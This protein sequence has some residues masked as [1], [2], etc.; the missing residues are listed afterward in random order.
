MDEICGTV[1]DESL[2]CPYVK[3]GILII[4]DDVTEI[5]HHAFAHRS[6]FTSVIIGENVTSIGVAAFAECSELTSVKIPDG[7]ISI[8]DFAINSERDFRKTQQKIPNKI[9]NSLQMI[10]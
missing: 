4:P 7:V 2:G 1:I 8:E 10:A 3:D 5:E 6:D 9:E